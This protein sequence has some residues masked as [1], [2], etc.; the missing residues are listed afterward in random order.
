MHLVCG[1][2]TLDLSRPVV[3][4]ILNVTPDSFS[5]GGRFFDPGVALEH[6]LRMRE[7]GAAIIDVGGES[8]RPGSE[9]VPA[10]EEIRR[11]VPVIRRLAAETDAIISVD[12]SKPEVMRAAAD[13]GAHMINDVYGLR[14]PGALEAAAAT[15]CAVCLM[16]MQG[17]PRTMQ[18]NPT[19]EEVVTEVKAFLLERVQACRDAGIDERRIVIDP[20]FGFGK[21]VEHNLELLRRLDELTATGWPVLAGLSRKSMLGR[22]LGRPVEERLAGSLALAMIAVE[23]GAR[24]MRVHDVAATVDV[25]KVLS[26]VREGG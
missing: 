24:I 10:E 14:L 1:T 9:P 4:G 23:R 7:E 11:V 16:H 18:V 15:D 19:Y 20:G 22:I 13:A 26:A 3:M 17:E 6:A 25:L 21:T 12:T 2:R 8:T 5:D